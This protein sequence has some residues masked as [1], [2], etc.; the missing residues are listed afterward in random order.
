MKQVSE[1]VFAPDAPIVLC[2]ERSVERIR[3]A[4]ASAELGR[5]RLCAHE[6]PEDRVHEMLVVQSA[7]SYVRPHR[8]RNKSESLLLLEGELDALFFDDR[9]AVSERRRMRPYAA[10]GPFYYRI[11]PLVWHA[12]VI[13]SPFIVMHEV[14]QGPLRRE[15][16]EFAA[17]SPDAAD[18]DAVA[19]YVETLRAL[20]IV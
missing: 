2:D 12:I 18:V 13:V 11:P 3:T 10:G 14:T 20:C 1:G 7:A 15:D 16:S 6:S 17:W 5:A 8:H 19:A 9:G 4:A